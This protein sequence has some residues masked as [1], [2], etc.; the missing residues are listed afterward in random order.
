VR[1]PSTTSNGAWFEISAGAGVP[2][3]RS[4]VVMV[5]ARAGLFDCA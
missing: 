3:A 2:I 1:K 5:M 4:L